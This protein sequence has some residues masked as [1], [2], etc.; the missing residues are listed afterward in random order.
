M[1]FKGGKKRKTPQAVA[2]ALDQMGA[3]S[4]AGTGGNTTTY[5]IKSAPQYAGQA[6]EILADMLIDA[7][8]LSGELEREKEVI[9]QELK[10][11]EDN[12]LAVL[13]EKRSNFFFGD[14]SYGRPIIGYEHTIRSFQPSNLF[15]YKESLYTKDNLLITI[16]GKI[17]DQTILETQIEKLFS[18][19]PEKR[20]RKKP[21]F[22]R[23][24]P[25]KKSDFFSKKT[26]QNH[27]IITMP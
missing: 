1:F 16:A 27:L 26:E 23:N 5:Y 24:L 25:E 9:I 4:N 22:K 17:E 14:T 12:P 11:Y 18:P 21:E 7:Q 6:L 10:M 19:L 8:F 13:N 3:E 15:A 20:T 2:I